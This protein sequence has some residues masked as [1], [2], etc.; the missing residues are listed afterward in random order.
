MKVGR[1]D[2]CICGSGKKYKKCCGRELIAPVEDFEWRRI[3][4][5]E[6]RIFDEHLFPYALDE[7]PKEVME[8]AFVEFLTVDLPD[9]IDP[10]TLFAQFFMPWF[11]F[12]WIIEDRFDLESINPEATIAENYLH[13][14]SSKLNEEERRFIEEMNKTYYSFYKVL[15]IIPEKA[16]V[17]E[18]LLLGSHPT[19]KEK[20]GTKSL[21]PGDIIFNRILTFKGQS[22][23]VGMAPYTLPS[24]CLKGVHEIKKEFKKQFRKRTL[25]PQFLREDGNYY[26]LDHYFEGLEA[27]YNQPM[28][29]ILNGEGESFE[30]TKSYFKT[31]ISV[32]ESLKRLLPM[33]VDEPVE[34]LLSQ[35]KKDETGRILELSM[36]WAREED[37]QKDMFSPLG[38]I[39]LKP[40]WIILEANSKERAEQGKELILKY[41]EGV[42]EFQKMLIENIDAAMADAKKE[43]QDKNL[44]DLE[45]IPDDL[46]EKLQELGNQHWEKWFDLAIPALGNKTPREAS[47][48]KKGREAIETLLKDYELADQSR[49]KNDP[50]KADIDYLKSKLGLTKRK[51]N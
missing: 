35:A 3:R 40:E 44:L 51:N 4:K 48:S 47:K 45:N 5:L 17:V 9:T 30:I 50:F 42:F 24:F 32:E 36:P 21:N 15:K 20:E 34:D 41:G 10:K 18:D 28:P 6:G 27:L 16:I 25:T 38:N 22:I 19:L 29:E 8:T 12:N 13:Q 1:N 46:Q 7:F 39:F 2:P 31:N 43:Q 11:V 49:K 37:R 14:N 26:L 23:S 33:T